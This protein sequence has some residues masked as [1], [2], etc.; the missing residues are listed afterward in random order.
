[1]Q[2]TTSANIVL[3]D[4]LD[5]MPVVIIIGI[6]LGI[7]LA[8]FFLKKAKGKYAMHNSYLG[9]IMIVFV[10]I[11]TEG[12]LNYTLYILKFSWLSKFSEPI[13]F[14]IAPLIYL[15]TIERLGDSRG[16]RDRKHFIPAIFWFVYWILILK[17]G[18]KYF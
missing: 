16:Y 4:S 3:K 5:L 11:F 15:F 8:Y 17:E 6:I 2:D 1:M 14:L 7:I 10:L 12:Y 13:N 9:F 18:L